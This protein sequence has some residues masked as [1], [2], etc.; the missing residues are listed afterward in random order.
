MADSS[1]ESHR[2]AKTTLSLI[3]RRANSRLVV[4]TLALYSSYQNSARR[5]PNL[6]MESARGPASKAAGVGNPRPE[7]V[8]TVRRPIISQASPMKSRKN[9]LRRFRSDSLSRHSAA[10]A[11]FIASLKCRETCQTDWRRGRDSNSR[12]PSGFYR[13]NSARDSSTIQLE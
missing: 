7:R 6:A 10:R 4:T 8:S 2:I 11:D 5:A 13:R 3:Q 12:D 9:C 1:S